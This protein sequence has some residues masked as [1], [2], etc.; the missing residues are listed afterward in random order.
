METKPK[1]KAEEPICEREDIRP[2]KTNEE[3]V[4]MALSLLI[5]T[6]KDRLPELT[7]MPGF[8][9]YD[10][11]LDKV[12][13]RAYDLNRD[14]ATEPLSQVDRDYTLQCLRG[15]NFKYAMLTGNLLGLIPSGND[16]DTGNFRKM[17]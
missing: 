7:Q 5:N 1:D 14:P 15:K 16:Q 2:I 11:T 9:I 3:A 12:R 17:L 13:E 4:R 6:P 8:L 10:L